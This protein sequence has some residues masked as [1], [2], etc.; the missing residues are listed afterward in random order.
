MLVVCVQSPGRPSLI[1]LVNWIYDCVCD[2]CRHYPSGGGVAHPVGMAF[3]CGLSESPVGC[4]YLVIR[5]LPAALQLP[6]GLAS[7]CLVGMAGK[8]LLAE[9]A[10]ALCGIYRYR[11]ASSS[12]Q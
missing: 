6:P 12:A 3:V 9:L 5:G 8:L 2:Q 10:L 7:R 11:G 4:F 1:I